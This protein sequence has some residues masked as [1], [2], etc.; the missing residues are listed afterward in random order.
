MIDI[1][2]TGAQVMMEKLKQFMAS[3][4]GVFLYALVTGMVGIIILL[5]FLSMV[6][7]PSV[8]PMILPGIIA[9]N[10]AAGGYS[11][12]EKNEGETGFP[13]IALVAIA[14]LLTITGCSVL[15][16][17]CPWEP[18]VDGIR[19]LVSILSALVFTFFGAWIAGKSKSLNR[20][21]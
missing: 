6:V 15:T 7:S 9:F 8:L 20:S 21:S 12:V 17:F 18:L 3:P 4:L 14:G 19:Y 11:L 2:T 10:A 1:C 13:K 5:A 16:L